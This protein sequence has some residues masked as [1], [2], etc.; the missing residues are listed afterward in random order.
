MLIIFEEIG[1]MKLV[2]FLLIFFSSVRIA[3]IESSSPPF[4]ILTILIANFHAIIIKA[5][6]FGEA[7]DDEFCLSFDA[8][9]C[10]V[11]PSVAPRWIGLIVKAD[12]VVIYAYQLYVA[13][14]STFIVRSECHASYL[15]DLAMGLMYWFGHLRKG[16]FW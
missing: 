13:D 5:G 4:P 1:K 14:M 3:D 11:E 12:L 8:L 7:L 6:T 2:I 10:E 9:D 16:K 15:Q